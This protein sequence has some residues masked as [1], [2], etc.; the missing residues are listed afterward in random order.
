MSSPLEIM[1]LHR[2][3]DKKQIERKDSVKEFRRLDAIAN[4]ER[5]VIDE[6][7]VVIPVPATKPEAMVWAML[8]KLNVPFQFQYDYP[9]SPYT[10][11]VENYRPDFMLPDYKIMIEVYGSYWHM[12]PEQI[13]QDRYKQAIYM[14]DGWS[15][16]IWWDWEIM[17]GVFKLFVRDLFELLASRPVRG[18]PAIYPLD[19]EAQRQAIKATTADSIIKQ[20]QIAGLKVWK[21]PWMKRRKE[22]REFERQWK[23]FYKRPR[24]LRLNPREFESLI[25]FKDIKQGTRYTQKDKWNSKAWADIEK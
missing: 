2:E 15:V 4:R 5:K 12:V 20:R 25:P 16:Y 1:N 10:E 7:S 9:D 24:D 19:A 6:S 14:M 8:E 23:N 18:G 11:A 21:D 3:I 22:P 13:Q 17:S